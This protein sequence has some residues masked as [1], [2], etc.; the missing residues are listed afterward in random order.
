MKALVYHGRQDLRYESFPEPIAAP[1]E[2]VV[3]VK[4]AGMCHT[5]FNEY[6]NGPT[7]TAA[8]THV[9]TGRNI[10]LVPGHEFAGQI[11]DVGA[12]VSNVKVGDRVAVNAVDAC[13]QCY[14]CKMGERALCPTVAFLGMGRD[15]GFAEFAAVQAECCHPLREGVSYRDAVLVEPLSV[16]VHAV[17]RAKLQ[18]GMDVAIVGGGTLGL[19]LLQVARAAGA[20][21]VFVIERAESKRKFCETLRGRFLNS[22][23]DINFRQEI[24]DHTQGR[25]VGVAF[26]C[27]GAPSALETAV[28]VTAAGGVICA[29]GIYPG[30]FPFDFNKVLGGEKSIVSSLAYG[31]EYPATIAM[32]A[33]GRLLA[34]PMI[35]HCVPLS[36]GCDHIREFERRGATNIKTLLEIDREE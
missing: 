31:T 34:E 23:S 33:D 11:V 21:D 32:L 24:L 12:K 8:T 3:K 29:T 20:R 16:A 15:G 19:C 26:E 22:K 7:F 36:Q 17:R 14:Y 30:P 9:R 18:I 13:G 1:D 28:E 25:G 35:T 5:D 2:V 10:P 27:A 6:E 4:Y